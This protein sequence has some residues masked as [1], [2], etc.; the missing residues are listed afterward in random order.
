VLTEVICAFCNK[1]R[2]FDLCRDKDLTEGGPWRCPECE[3]AYD[4]DAIEQTIVDTLLHQNMAFQLQDLLCGKCRAVKA[5]NVAEHCH[6]S[7]R[8]VETASAPAFLARV[9]AAYRLAEFH[10]LEQLRDAAAWLLRRNGVAL[11]ELMHAAA[12]A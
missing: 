4:R 6:C 10:H 2:D 1:C 9:A 5:E 8:F 7:G 12:E 3:H 11:P